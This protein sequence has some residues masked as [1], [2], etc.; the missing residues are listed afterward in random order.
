M[1]RTGERGHHQQGQHLLIDSTVRPPSAGQAPPS[2]AASQ[3]SRHLHLRL[4]APTCGR[5]SAR[6]A[7]GPGFSLS[8]LLSRHGGGHLSPDGSDRWQQGGQGSPV[9]PAAAMSPPATPSQE[10]ASPNTSAGVIED[11]PARAGTSSLKLGKWEIRREKRK[12]NKPQRDR[13]AF[14]APVKIN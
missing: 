1:R 13:M 3:R 2:Q 14:H 8:L 10:L 6:S 9:L 5:P 7:W 4:T 11:R 12:S